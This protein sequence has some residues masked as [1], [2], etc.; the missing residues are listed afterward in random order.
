MVA[1]K[2]HNFCIDEQEHIPTKRFNKD[3]QDGDTWEVLLNEEDKSE[4]TVE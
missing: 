2:L 3:V 4:L 1:A